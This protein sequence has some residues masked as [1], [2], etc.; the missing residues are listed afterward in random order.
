MH[1]LL[2]E[3]SLGD[4]RLLR[5]MIADGYQSPVEIEH[6]TRLELALQR[7]QTTRFDI[8][9]LDLSL[10][11]THGYATFERMYL[12]TP[13][14]PII[15]LSGMDDETLAVRAAREGAQDYLRKEELTPALLVRAM[16]YAIERKRSEEALK[17]ERAQLAQR[18]EERTAALRSANEK[19][20]LAAQAKDEFLAMVSHELRTPLSVILMLTESLKKGIYGGLTARQSDSLERVHTSG[21]HLLAL[22]NDLLDVA[23]IESKNLR[24]DITTVAARAVCQQALEMV[25]AMAQRR[26]IRLT[27]KVDPN[28]S[29]LLADEH[30]L[31]QILVNLLNNAIKFTPAGGQ[32]GLE[33]E[34]DPQTATL[35]FTVWDTG[36]GI[37]AQDQK[38]LFQPFVQ[39]DQ[40]LSRR[41]EGS[42]LGLALVYRLVELHGGSIT[43]TSNVGQ[44]SRFT[45]TL[46]WRVPVDA[47]PFVTPEA[48][49]SVSR[50]LTANPLVLIADDS[51][52]SLDVLEM[53][54]HTLAYRVMI[55]N[56]GIEAV[57]YAYQ[58]QPDLIL[59][60]IQMPN[61]NGLEA[62]QRIRAH[63]PLQHTPVF[64]LT[65]LAMPG[66]RDRCLAAGATEYLTKPVSLEHLTRLI[67]QYLS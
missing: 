51:A 11:D 7:L 23:K 47:Q 32:A 15:I 65:A 59:M 6:F 58:H 54:L 53:Y 67:E 12:Q 25:E 62:I 28:A 16:H 30:R 57:Q 64:A 56:D 5:E 44:G 14:T 4:A 48:T 37:S 8:I 63:L 36:I 17:V 13:Q 46:P 9:L 22:I 21:N 39:I 26:E 31:T 33:V 41:Y 45:V 43:L 50:R 1:L 40:S 29:L 61:M 38:K 2:V 20:L 34:G 49:K 52:I 42:G 3:D 18:V 19:L 35:R 27:H 55:A 66:D 10:P 60:D 24:L